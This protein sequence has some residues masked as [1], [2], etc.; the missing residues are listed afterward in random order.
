M[1]AVK[2]GPSSATRSAAESAGGSAM[3]SV[4]LSAG[5]SDAVSAGGLRT[6]PQP[7]HPR[8]WRA[9]RAL[10]RQESSAGRPG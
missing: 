5:G 3:V 10:L 6:A 2:L 8:T 7:K 9:W 4:G 1:L